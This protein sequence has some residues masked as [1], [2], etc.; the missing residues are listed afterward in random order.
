MYIYVLLLLLFSQFLFSG[1]DAHTS[2]GTRW[3]NVE[4]A[5]V[6][7]A[8]VSDSPRGGGEAGEAG[9]AVRVLL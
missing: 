3:V 6:G 2:V 7:N 4:A 1:P 8:A 5:A 9:V